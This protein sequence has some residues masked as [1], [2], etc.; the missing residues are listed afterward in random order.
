MNHLQQLQARGEVVTGLIYIDPKAS[1]L[2]GALKTVDKPLNALGE[3]E[4]CPGAAALAKI[5]A[6]LR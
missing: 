6:S 1:D 5:N 4:L 3:A 2:H